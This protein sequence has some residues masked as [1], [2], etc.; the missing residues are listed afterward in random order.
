MPVVVAPLV[1]APLVVAPLVV[2]PLVVAPLVEP[3]LPLPVATELLLV[4]E[5][6]VELVLPAP[7]SFRPGEESSRPPHA[8][9]SA[10]PM[11]PAITPE[12]TIVSILTSDTATRFLR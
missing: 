3:P 10:R 2:A 4:V 11:V 5:P 1:V 12:R 9:K 8:A 7:P 6:V